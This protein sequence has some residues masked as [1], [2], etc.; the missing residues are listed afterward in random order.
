[1]Q[2]VSFREVSDFDN[3][4]TS[5]KSFFL[6]IKRT[7]SRIFVGLLFSKSLSTNQNEFLQG[8]S[9]PIINGVI[10]LSPIQVGI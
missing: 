10:V 9:L 4:L 7:P 6:P 5:L 8:G 2:A 3:K 1:M